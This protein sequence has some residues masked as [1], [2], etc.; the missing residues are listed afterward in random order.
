MFDFLL[1]GKE[2]GFY[3]FDYR[4][5]T[6]KNRDLYFK[7]EDL[8]ENIMWDFKSLLSAIN[9]DSFNSTST[10]TTLKEEIWGQKCQD[11]PK[12]LYSLICERV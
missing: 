2:I 9:N 1:T 12:E 11:E 3:P 4:E 10:L 8:L 7:Y 5:Y 6:S